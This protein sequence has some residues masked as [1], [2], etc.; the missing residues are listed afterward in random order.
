[1]TAQS[2]V[3]IC[4]VS[5]QC[6][7]R[8]NVEMSHVLALN[9]TFHVLTKR[10]DRHHPNPHSRSDRGE[11]K[12]ERKCGGSTRRNETHTHTH[13]PVSQKRI[14]ADRLGTARCACM[15]ASAIRQ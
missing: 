11:L 4:D 5:W 7:Y 6:E 14:R 3:T 13:Q 10:I 2:A 1:M 8:Q 9:P 12:M 15:C